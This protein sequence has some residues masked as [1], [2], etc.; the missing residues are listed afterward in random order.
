MAKLSAALEELLNGRHY[1]TLATLNDDGSMD[2]TPV[3]YLWENECLFVE[4]SSSTRKV[5][6]LIARPQASLMVDIRK[7]G[8]ERWV[9][10]SGSAEILRGEHSKEINTKILR[11]YLTPAGLE[12]PGVG[13]VF[14]A[15]DDV[16]IR[17]T[18]REWRSWDF[19]S[20]DE[21]YFGGR[22]VSTPQQWFLPLD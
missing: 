12:D 17:L 15:A 18:P 3:W 11:R 2:L 5:K 19:K 16:T 4:T 10:A 20:V 6:N 9:S 7:L 21:R 22:L 8:S 1:A 14:A 13:A